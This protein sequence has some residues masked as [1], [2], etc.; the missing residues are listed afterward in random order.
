MGNPFDTRTLRNLDHIPCLYQHLSLLKAVE[1]FVNLKPTL[2]YNSPETFEMM[3]KLKAEV[4]FVYCR[5][6]DGGAY[7]I[8]YK[9]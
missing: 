3:A 8:Y 6:V 1:Q 4:N 7:T 9:G 2:G 5:V